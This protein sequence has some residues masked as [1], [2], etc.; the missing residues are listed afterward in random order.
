MATYF[1]QNRHDLKI[2]DPSTGN[3]MGF[4]CARNNNV[5][6]YS[7]LDGKSLV[8]LYASDVPTQVNTN[9]EEELLLGSST[10]VAGFGKEY[11]DMG[12]TKR[13]FESYGCDLSQ[14]GQAVAGWNS[15]AVSTF[16]IM[17]IT[18]AWVSPTSGAGT[19]WANVTNAYDDNTG[20]YTAYT[21]G[22]AGATGY[23]TYVVPTNYYDALRI[24]VSEGVPSITNVEIGVYSGA[25]WTTVNNADLTAGQWNTV[26]FAAAQIVTQVR[27]KLTGD[28]A[29]EVNINELDIQ[30]ADGPTP[31]GVTAA[32]ADFNGLHYVSK[33]AQLLKMDAAGSSFTSVRVFPANITDLVPFQVSGT[34]YLFIFI[35]L[36]NAYWYMTTA[37][38]FTESSAAVT[39]F[40]FGAYVNTT[41]DTMYA[42]DTNNSIRS[43][44][45]PL[46]GGTAWSA[47]TV[48]G[49][50][51]YD[52]THLQEKGGALLIDKEVMPYYLSSAGAVQKSL[53]PEC[54]SGVSTHSGKNSTSWKGEYYRPTGDQ[55][56]LRSGDANEWIQPSAFT[57]N[58][59]SFT[60]QVEA[61]AGDEE[62]L[63]TAT[64]NITNTV[65]EDFE[66]GAD[67]ASLA[68]SGGTV[69][70][71]VSVTGT[72]K[73][74][75]DTAQYYSGTRSARLYRDGTND[76]RAY[77]TQAP[78]STNQELSFRFRKDDT[79]AFAVLW[80]NGTR[81]LYLVIPATEALSYYDADEDLIVTGTSVSINTWYLLETRNMNWT[82]GT[83]DIY[84]NGVLITAGAEMDTSADYSGTINFFNAAGTSEVW[85]DDVQI[86]TG[87]VEIFKGRETTLDGETRWV[88]H[89]IHELS[90]YDTE[91]MWIS[92]VYQK[93]L[94]IS[95][96]STH[97]TLSYLPLPTKY[98]DI[99]LDSNASFKTDTYFI[100]PWLH[101]GFYFDT[102]GLI[103]VTGVLGHAYDADIYW[104]CHYQK[105]GDTSWTDMGDL[106]G[107][108]TSRSATLYITSAVSSPMFRFKFVAKTDNTAKTPILL[109]YTVKTV[110][111]ST[112]KRIIYTKVH[113]GKGVL[114]KAGHVF[115]DNY[116]LQKTCLENMKNASWLTSVMEY[117]TDIKSGSSMNVKLLTLPQ[118][119]SWRT[120]IEFENDPVLEYT[121]LMLKVPTS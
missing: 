74:E 30:T 111:S 118:S 40:Q 85:I 83:Y 33:G 104:E 109:S 119:E 44:I 54:K 117:V 107:S 66:W 28:G 51:A 6:V 41:V 82:A 120:P 25:A 88:W 31:S 55:A 3:V 69:T 97:S 68:T 15:T 75:I 102:K 101:G 20:T 114:D 94:Y 37:E 95:S 1:Q 99:T 34:D 58:S 13:Y 26:T 87:K 14:D 76:V 9:P 46:N 96:T 18:P 12:D 35:G 77:F 79:S 22:G 106:K 105:L 78:I 2:T 4:I 92:S 115:D 65:S 39:A 50:D 91:T 16:N 86:K 42:N 121:L 64:R 43:T 23:Y 29:G 61:C 103:K 24:W 49:E 59:S 72:S 112:P 47:A 67:A 10:N 11:Y 63:Y 45:N 108:A 5:P 32:H 8:D 116:T 21:L 62:W 56:L 17:N 89:P 73:A 98:G 48:V 53:A 113:V 19:S 57:T 110:L 70:W 27:V 71:T 36:S 84:L 38:A 93:R 7:E 52:I 100:T 60:G 80:G 90:L 81:Y